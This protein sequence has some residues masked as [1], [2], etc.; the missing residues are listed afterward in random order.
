VLCFEYLPNG[1]LEKYISDISTCESRYYSLNL[2]IAIILLDDNM[3]PKITDFGLS[4]CFD[5][6]LSR[7]FDE[8]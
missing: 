6:G 5:F 1:S 2:K 4:R 3:V 7:C 8:M